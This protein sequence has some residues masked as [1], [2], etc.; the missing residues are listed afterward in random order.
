MIRLHIFCEGQTE[1][2]F[3]REL[4]E[5][6]LR[7]FNTSVN[8]IILR[9]SPTGKGGI[10]TYG[11]I[12]NQVERKCKEDPASLVTTLIDYYALPSDFPGKNNSSTGISSFDRAVR[13]ENE[14]QADIGHRNF[15]ANLLIH[16]YEGLLYSEPQAFERSGWFDKNVVSMIAE[17]RSKFENP[18]FINDSPASAPSKRILSYCKSYNKV[19]HGPQIAL[20]IG[21]EKIRSECRHFNEWLIRLEN[22]K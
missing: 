16:E 2:T 1:E 5:P 8:T 10:S 9:T 14:F 6:H 18:E 7:S 4:I 11:K 17:T 21:L 3:V 12:K 15:I 22:L 20:E 13:V 19:L